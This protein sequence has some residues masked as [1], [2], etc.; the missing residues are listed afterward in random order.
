MSVPSRD[1][2][3]SMAPSTLSIV[4]RMRT[5]GG[6]CWAQATDPSTDKTVSEATS[7][8]G[9]N[10]EILGMT[11]SSQ[12]VSGKERTPQP[13]GLF[14]GKTSPVIPGW[15]EGPDHRCAIARG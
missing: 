4:P 8:R 6:A 1:L 12:G 11:F 15:S 2:I 3:I 13:V 9:I 10:E 7:A 14:H 5:G